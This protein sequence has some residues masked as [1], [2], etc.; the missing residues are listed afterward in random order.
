MKK[1]LLID[2]ILREKASS[3]TLCLP[4]D[5]DMKIKQTL[6]GLQNRKRKNNKLTKR[7]AAAAAIITVIVI[8]LSAVF[9]A[10]A[11]NLPIISSVFEFL[12]EKN[13][14]DRDYVEYSS[15]LNL[16]KVSN[17]VKVT[18]NSI[19]YDGIDLSITYTVESKEEMK[20]EPHILDKEFKIN[21]KVKSFGSGGTGKLINNKTYV[22]VDSFQVANDY[23]P[24]EIKKDIVGGT[25]EIPDNFIMN[26]DIRAFSNGISGE[27]NFRFKVSKDKIQGKVKEIKS[28][29]DLSQIRADLKVMGVIFTP[30]NTVLRTV[31]DNTNDNDM[32]DFI[33]FDDKERGFELK[34]ASANGSPEVN[35]AY[36]EYIF[37]NV[38][39]DTSSVT[40]IPVTYS[41]E[42]KEKEKISNGNV[43]IELKEVPLNLTG[44]ATLS[45]GR[46]G[47]YKIT[48]IE[49]LDG[50]TLVH[51]ECTNLLATKYPYYL[52]IIDSKGKEYDFKREFV[53][54]EGN[55]FIAEI[56]PLSKDEQYK[57]SG[58]D[59]EKMYE[60][61]EDLKFTID[62]K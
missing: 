24:E 28:S 51:Y 29:I 7:A 11:R 2:D 35:Q 23:L 17:D 6:A 19:V 10:Y 20:R 60:V 62:L 53:K 37:S 5:L 38:Y 40:F 50:K 32:I 3:E 52:T 4:E 26:L 30:I 31:E 54:K 41:K 57:L 22:G 46:L 56:E 15:D 44:T 49:F 58:F 16:S 48:Q 21:G 25:V 13:L 47:E 33:A 34:H 12:S 59:Y 55:E 8:S 61:R 14:I 42:Y 36:W 27:W 9:P 1:D 45:Q 18:I 43:K 39:E